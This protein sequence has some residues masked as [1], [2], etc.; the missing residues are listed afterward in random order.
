MLDC[1]STGLDPLDTVV[2]TVVHENLEKVGVDGVDVVLL[3]RRP[4]PE[5]RELG[6]YSERPS[7]T[8]SRRYVVLRVL[9]A[10]RTAALAAL[11]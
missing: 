10:G 11:A 1:N 7:G 9:Q 2:E 5:E 3:L 6:R 4:G 8:S